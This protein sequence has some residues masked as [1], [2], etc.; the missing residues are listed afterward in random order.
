[1]RPDNASLSNVDSIYAGLIAAGK[2]IGT[3]VLIGIV[4]YLCA[5]ERA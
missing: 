5:L 1:M 4:W 3:G 2:V